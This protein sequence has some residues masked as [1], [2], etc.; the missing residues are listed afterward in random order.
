MRTYLDS[1]GIKHE[2]RLLNDLFK[3]YKVDERPVANAT[4]VVEVKLSV[5][6]QQLLNLVSTSNS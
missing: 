4:D 6:Y 1:K 2:R 3:D 5:V